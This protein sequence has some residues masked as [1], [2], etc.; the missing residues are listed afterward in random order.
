MEREGERERRESVL[1]GRIPN[2][3]GAVSMLEFVLVA[4]R[5]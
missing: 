5:V 3:T 1:T 4:E 2:Q